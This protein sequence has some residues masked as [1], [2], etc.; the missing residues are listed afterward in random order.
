MKYFPRY[1]S[2][3][4]TADLEGEL[5][6]I[7]SG[8]RE[9]REV[10]RRFWRDFAAALADTSELRISEVLTA[11]DEAL[12]PHL[13]PARADGGDPRNARCAGPGG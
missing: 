11:I 12:A 5:D 1:V 2:Y 6:D 9:Y 3:D 13:Y 8:S 10:L 7:S 4:F